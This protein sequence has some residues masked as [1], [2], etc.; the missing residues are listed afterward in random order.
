LTRENLQDNATEYL[1]SQIEKYVRE[2]P[3]NRFTGIDGAPIFDSPLVG[4]ANG[5]DPIFIEYKGI[6]GPAHFTP[7]EILQKTQEGSTGDGKHGME[8]ISVISW[9]LP[10]TRETRLSNRREMKEPS[11]RWAHTRYYGEQLND[12]LRYYLVGLLNQAGYV[13]CAPVVSNFFEKYSDTAGRDFSSNW[14]ERHIAYAAGLGAFGLNE[15]FI[16]Q[17]GIAVRC[18]SV[19]TNLALPPTPRVYA[20]H[21][22]NCLYFQGYDCQKCIQRCPAGAISREGHD[23]AKCFDY[24]RS[25]WDRLNADYQVGIAGCGLCQTCVPCEAMIP[26]AKPRKGS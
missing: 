6:I 7:R 18:G 9:I 13:A 12:A 3:M 17:K 14:S 2:H 20:N 1:S 8:T 22:S 21:R 23:K 19:V 24:T 26:A 11:L 16:T 10:I 15:G 4:I 5:H 25:Y